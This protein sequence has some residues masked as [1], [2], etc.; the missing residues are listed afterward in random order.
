MTGLPSLSGLRVVEA[1]Q[2]LVGP[3][4]GWHL[5]MLGATVVKVEPPTGDIAR[6]WD[7]GRLFDV[8]NGRK[9]CAAFDFQVAAERASFE[10]LCAECDILIADA[11]WSATQVLAASRHPGGRVGSIVVVDDGPVPGGSGSSET[12]AQAA[13]AITGYIG[14]PQR[15]RQRL[16]A[17]IASAA[18][19]STVVQ[20][21][22]AGLVREDNA[23]PLV[24]RVSIDRALATL[25]T[26]HWAARSD[27][28]EWRGYHVRAVSRP[29]DR[30]YR[31]RDGKITLDFLPD[32]HESWRAL[33]EEIGL[34]DLADEVGD[35]WYSTV[36]MEDRIDWARPR[37]ERAFAK[38]GRDEAIKIIRKHD[39]WSVPF[40]EPE[41]ALTH[42]QSRLYASAFVDDEKVTARLPWRINDEPQG[43]HEPKQA[44]PIGAD[45]NKVLDLVKEGRR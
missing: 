14:D 22:L 18:A 2:R 39:G 10:A 36:G 23:G 21:A 26:I 17:D 13:M 30:G 7:G 31:T 3:L 41:Q 38:Y 35:D 37:Y 28:D 9:L 43:S 42:P 16:G 32:Q 12:L 20:A 24:S 11:S 40:Q 33:C 4:A 15:P 34:S 27:P 19:A 8:L 1:C 5:A 29:P 6:D 44:P 45:N 25:K